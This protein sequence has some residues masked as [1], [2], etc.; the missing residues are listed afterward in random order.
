M[1]VKRL[2]V[3]LV[4]LS[5]IAAVAWGVNSK[6]GKGTGP[7][8]SL[9]LDVTTYLWVNSIFCVVY[10]QGNFGYDDAAA[11]GKIDGFYYPFASPLDTKSVIYAAGIW[12]G[13]QV[14]GDTRVA[15]AEYSSEFVPGKMENNTWTSDRASYKVYKIGSGPTREGGS[16]D[17]TADY[18]NWPFD[19]GAP[20][21]WVDDGEG[22]QEYVPDMLG[23]QMCW[24]VY[25]DAKADA[26]TNMETDPL[27]IEIQQSTFGFAMKGPLD[28]II[29]TK[30]VIYNKGLNTLENT[31]ISLWADPDVG[32]AG[33]DLVGCDTI[34]SL[35]YCYNSGS[36]EIYGNA[37]PAVGFDFFQGPIVPSPGD[38][39]Y[40]PYDTIPDM[41]VL[42]MSS[43]NKYINGTDP[44]TAEEVYN[45]MMGLEPDGEP[46]V[47]PDGDTTTFFMSG[48]PVADSGWIDFD[49]ADRRYMMST[50][51]FTMAPG[52]SQIV[53]AAMLASQGDDPLDA[54]SQLKEKDKFAQTVYD[55][56][57]DIPQPPPSPTVYAR[58][59]DDR[60]ELVW[61][62]DSEGP[63]NYIQDYRTK[64]GQL[65]VFEG[66]N[67]YVG[68]TP[69]GP[70]T[71]LATF[72]YD[73]DQMQAAYEDVVGEYADCVWDEELEEWD[74]TS[75]EQERI[76]DFALLYEDKAKERIISQVGDNTG[77]YYQYT[78]SRDPRDGT[79]IITNNPY[80]F[81][82]TAYGVNIQQINAEDSVFFGPNF[83]GMLSANL[84]SR[85]EAITVIP[86][87]SSAT[88]ER[89]G[90]RQSGASDGYVEVEYLIQDSL[91]GHDYEVTFNSDLTWNLTDLTT[92]EE[93]LENQ[94]N[95]SGDFAYPIVHGMMVRVIGPDPGFKDIEEVYQDEESGW[96][97]DGEQ[98]YMGGRNAGNNANFRDFKVKFLAGPGDTVQ[99]PVMEYDGEFYQTIRY[100]DEAG[101]TIWGYF[102]GGSEAE[103]AEVKVSIPF[104]IYDLGDDFESTDDDV[105]LWPLFYDFYG[106]YRWYSD[107]YFMFLTR[108]IGGTDANIY[109]NNFFSYA[110]HD[111]DPDYYNFDPSDPMSRH[112][113]DYRIYGWAPYG[114]LEGWTV[115]DS[116][117]FVTNK[118]NTPDD[119][120]TFSAPRIGDGDGTFIARTMDNI[121][122]V[123]NPYYNWSRWE[124]DQ[125][126]RRIKFINMPP[127]VEVEV[128]IF[129]LAGD[130][131]RTLVHPA[132]ENAELSWDVKT[133]N[134]LYVASGIYIY[135]AESEIGQKVGKMAVFTEVEQLNVY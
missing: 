68:D 126:S 46:V 7:A 71:W 49:P 57:F 8:T 98:A 111:G 89:D 14:A 55:L 115:G 120:F 121:K 3:F 93:V 113:W 11:F 69:S 2:I 10:N 34:L 95:L 123:P 22:G 45:Y 90:D 133:D 130:L 61:K 117:V 96:H 40:L 132:G 74:C 81:A 118:A 16:Y 110:P 38:T 9:T 4:I 42:P 32:D 77:T 5:L 105:R 112:D 30:F 104:A 97:L 76:W 84:E 37:V 80:Y 63:E 101:D 64:L 87:G 83:Q 44:T 62:P 35:G 17:Q 27:G 127:G 59:H 21:K 100:L 125:F 24:S 94:P 50:G 41:K 79:A 99:G 70:W 107:D 60:M 48:D 75:A 25:N 114:A 13:A 88:L 36:D 39:A 124:A 23:N 6:T 108:D 52:D 82:V 58:G 47:T 72:D 116:I 103:E 73:A 19:D 65:F 12:V 131:V 26:H 15:I 129:N 66:Y 1:H 92:G 28:N 106:D 109:G 102:Y 18:N 33:D 78:T 56:N 54:I 122:T 86:L 43:F 91:T 134:G 53:V 85:Q 135:L 128:K 31:Y 29:F 51:P 119:V 20:G 67:V